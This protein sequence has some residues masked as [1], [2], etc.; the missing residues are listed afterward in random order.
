VISIA[1]GT[2]TYFMYGLQLDA[3]KFFI[4]TSILV[5]GMFTGVSCMLMIGKPQ[6]LNPKP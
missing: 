2:L 3:G 1:M 6:T 5:V 4:W